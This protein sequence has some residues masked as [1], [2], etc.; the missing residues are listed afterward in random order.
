MAHTQVTTARIW[1]QHNGDWVRLALKDL[2]VIEMFE[3]G[4][5][6]EGSYGKWSTYSRDGDVI[7]CDGE[8]SERDCDGSHSSAW[9]CET[10]IDALKSGP[11]CE[12]DPEQPP[13]P[14]WRAVDSSQRDYSA[15][16]AGY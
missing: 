10:T 2:D 12:W 3:G 9:L 15:E 4:P 5:T 6:D 8:K 11:A 7:T 16:A 13:T 1:V 14:Q